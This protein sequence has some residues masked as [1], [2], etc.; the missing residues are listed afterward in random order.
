MKFRKLFFSFLFLIPGLFFISN[1]KAETFIYDYNSS[2]LDLLKNNLNIVDEIKKISD[3]FNTNNYTYYV[4]YYKSY[5]SFY[6]SVGVSTYSCSSSFYTFSYS[7]SNDRDLY[8]GVVSYLNGNDNFCEDFVQTGSKL[9]IDYVSLNLS[10]LTDENLQTF[11]TSVKSFFVN[12]PNKYGSMQNQTYQYK[13]KLDVFSNNNFSVPVYS[14]SKLKYVK[15]YDDTKTNEKLIQIDD[16]TYNYDDIIPTYYDYFGLDNPKT[17]YIDSSIEDIDSVTIDDIK[18]VQKKKL[19]LKFNNYNLVK[20]KIFIAHD[21]PKGFYEITPNIVTNTYSINF[22]KDSILYLKILDRETDEVIY[23]QTFDISNISYPIPSL[24]LTLTDTEYLGDNQTI[25]PLHY[26]YLAEFNYFNT[27]KYTYKY[28]YPDYDS[29]IN[30]LE[31]NKYINVGVNGNMI[32]YVYDNDTGELVYTHTLDITGLYGSYFPQIS[33]KLYETEYLNCGDEKRVYSVAIDVFFS[34]LDK[35]KYIYEYSF[36]G[37]N[38]DK[39]NI[40]SD[41]HYFRHTVYSNSI[42]YVRILDKNN[43]EVLASQTFDISNITY[44][45]DDI[46]CILGNNFNSNIEALQKYLVGLK[47]TSNA[48][49]QIFDA[50]YKSLPVVV[51]QGL[52]YIY[53][54]VLI[55][56]GLKIGGWK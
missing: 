33:M 13:S 6:L 51:S 32:F 52:A 47:E 54:I 36:D 1:V 22:E 28:Y 8:N 20:Y 7:F 55:I 15:R 41:G 56:V 14:N 2:N 34:I 31:N 24:K 17:P 42:L 48:F 37:V 18:Y 12:G 23:T 16:I 38:Y 9:L 19:K 3:E 5:G 4:S 11:L 49:N 43:D 53:I 39:Y 46:T 50:F 40:T 35:S 45:K 21:V 27:E 30:M 44:D 26:T 25:A 29:I 10:N